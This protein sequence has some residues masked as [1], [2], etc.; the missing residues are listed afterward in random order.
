MR[1]ILFALLVLIA[2]VV[3]LWWAPVPRYD[4]TAYYR[5][6]GSH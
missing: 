5:Y 1:A 3:A 6:R 4:P 2:I